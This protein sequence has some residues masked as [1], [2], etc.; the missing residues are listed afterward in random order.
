MLVSI[1]QLNF[2]HSAIP[3][4]KQRLSPAIDTLQ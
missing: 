3:T 4:S 2:R 1:F